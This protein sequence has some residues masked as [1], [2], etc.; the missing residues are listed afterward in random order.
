[1]RKKKFIC[2]YNKCVVD[3]DINCGELTVSTLIECK[4]V[5]IIDNQTI[6]ADGKEVVFISGEI[7]SIY[8]NDKEVWTK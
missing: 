7:E 1:M 5:E 3:I 4:E 8:I 2:S 6:K